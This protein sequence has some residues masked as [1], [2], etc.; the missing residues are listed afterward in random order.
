M[1][2][3]KEGIYMHGTFSDAA[4]CLSCSA[5]SLCVPCFWS[6]DWCCYSKV[7]PR[8]YVKVLENALE[9]NFAYMP[10][11]P[12]ECCIKDYVVKTYFDRM[13]TDPF[14]ATCC[15]PYHTCFCIECCGQVTAFSPHPVCSNTLC[16]FCFPCFFKYIPG[17]TDAASL[18]A[19]IKAAKDDFIRRQATDGVAGCVVLVVHAFVPFARQQ[20]P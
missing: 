11:C 15:T 3:G 9:V 20:S 2:G 13:N 7:K 1:V 8:T 4:G 12:L 17:L 18:A 14:R 16:L 19:Y 6:F 5:G 10:T